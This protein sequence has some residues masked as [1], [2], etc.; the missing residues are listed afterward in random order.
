[1]FTGT[2]DCMKKGKKK[3]MWLPDL[4]SGALNLQS[5]QRPAGAKG[6]RK[7]KL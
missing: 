7:R 5:F 3:C 2:K 4:K 1:M 6:N